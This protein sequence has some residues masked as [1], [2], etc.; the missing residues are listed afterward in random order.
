M[1][2]LILT[3]VLT[4]EPILQKIKNN[5]DGK[6]RHL[7]IVP[8]RFTLSYEKSA[9]DYLGS[10]ETEEKQALEYLGIKGSF[11]LEV[12]SFS[13]LA[14][15]FL[16]RRALKLLDKQ[17]EI[18]LLRKVIEENKSQLVCFGRAVRQAGFAE[19]M[20]AAISQI[21]NSGVKAEQLE[22]MQASLDAKTAAKTHDVALLYARY[23]QALQERYVDG[24]S[25]LQAFADGVEGSELADYHIYLTDFTSL[26]RVE[27]DIVQAMMKTALSFDACLLASRADNSF[28]Y[29]NSM[30]DDF[31]AMAHNA[32]QTVNF[33][34]F[35]ANL[36]GDF[37]ML[38]NKLFSCEKPKEPS[39][40]GQ[41]EICVAES[42]EEEI[43]NVAR[44]INSLIRQGGVRYKDIAIVC[45]DFAAYGD[46]IYKIFDDF[47]ISYYCDVKTPLMTQ[48]LTKTLS[49]AIKAVLGR[50]G[51]SEVIAFA[52]SPLSG[53]D[54]D[55]VCIFENYCLERGVEYGKFF[56]G[57]DGDD[58]DTLTAEKV[59]QSVCD[60]LQNLKCDVFTVEQASASIDQFMTALS[61][62]EKNQAFA[63]KQKQLGLDAE[64]AVTLQCYDKI[65]RILEQAVGVMGNTPIN[66]DEFFGIFNSA[67]ASVDVSTAPLFIDS[68]FV[69]EMTASRFENVKY[70]FVVGA[71]ENVFPAQS[72]DNGIVSE[73]E[74]MA[75][76]KNGVVVEPDVKARNRMQKLNVLTTILKAEKKL[77]LS[78]SL[79]DYLM[80]PC[81]SGSTIDYVRELC[82]VEI[83]RADDPTD[84][85]DE[86]QVAQYVSSDGNVLNELIELVNLVKNNMWGNTDEQLDALDKVY[87]LACKRY[88]RDYVDS[89]VDCD[90]KKQWNAGTQGLAWKDGCSSA[91]QFECYF[92]CPFK[93]FLNYIVRVKRRA[94]AK[95]EVSDLGT[96]LHSIAERYFT[97][98]KCC[99][100]TPEQQKTIVDEIFRKMCDENKKL[101]ILISQPTGKSLQ[102]KITSRACFMIQRLTQ[103]MKFTKFRPFACEKKF[104][105]S[106]DE[107]LP[108]VEIDNGNRIINI[109]GVIDRIDTYKDK[110]FVID[111][112]SKSKID[113]KVKNI[114][115]GDRIQMLIYIMA[116]AS[117]KD[118]TPAGMFYVLMNDKYLNPQDDA[119]KRFRYFGYVDANVDNVGDFDSRLDG[120]VNAKSDLYDL[121]KKI[122]AK[123]SRLEGSIMTGDDILSAC[124]YVKKLMQKA[125]KE[126][127]EGYIQPKPI[128]DGCKFCEY[129]NI[130]GIDESEQSERKFAAYSVSKMREQIEKSQAGE[131][132]D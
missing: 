100:Y 23:V 68:V 28:I 104:G 56:V 38:K 118:F 25:K 52:K 109:K 61:L 30:V 83:N 46:E 42:V 5:F 49:C 114:L 116:V 122:S 44:K 96:Y 129:K 11:E 90:Y 27:K 24:T 124:G 66:M 76:A 14:D 95:L 9:I 16:Q 101:A 64:S 39:Q 40:A 87:T 106:Y 2:N 103:K 22:T 12:A 94:E 57:F 71:N 89:I 69:G 88:G 18:M 58:E 70:M 21:R 79:K 82:G 132:N 62:E 107:D 29:P 81:A 92:N 102:S 55:D 113:F 35:R 36:G 126:I 33:E 73:R 112:K 117:Q 115:F 80:Q 60:M 121:R 7:L 75:W 120:D 6:S 48:A 1:I 84:L 110:F 93:H 97:D 10:G 50:W 53:L 131:D 32:N 108:P 78:Y 86:S 98:P 91:S 77:Y 45:C 47:D 54:Y 127:D 72:G 8:D 4:S 37:E 20:Y 63:E 51:Q 128:K 3:P 17:S 99:D 41:V 59:R 123:G 85:W 65:K 34:H 111:Y 13:K 19:E 15:R 74:A 67:V 43:K 130:C 125:A 31:V 26:T 105:F 119:E